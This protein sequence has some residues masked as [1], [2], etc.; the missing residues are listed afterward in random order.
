MG[1]ELPAT[2][3]SRVPRRPFMKTSSV[4]CPFLVISERGRPDVKVEDEETSKS[5]PGDGSPC[6][7]CPPYSPALLA[8]LAC[9]LLCSLSFCSTTPC[10]CVIQNLFCCRAHDYIH[11]SCRRVARDLAYRSYRPI[12][13]YY[14]IASYGSS[15]EVF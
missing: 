5:A 4:G 1:K 6:A 2:P 10:C 9:L 13:V 11:E 14:S 8:V 15:L 12:I 3:R 7:V